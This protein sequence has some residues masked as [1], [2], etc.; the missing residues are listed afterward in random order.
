MR[1]WRA[2]LVWV[3]VKLNEH[4]AFFHPVLAVQAFSR[5]ACPG[6]APSGQVSRGSRIVDVLDC[7]GEFEAVAPR[8]AD[9]TSHVSLS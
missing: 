6:K 3:W 8:L 1:S 5:S 4:V 9:Q 7:M 2:L